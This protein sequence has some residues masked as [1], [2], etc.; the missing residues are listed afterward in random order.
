MAEHEIPVPR[1]HL[2]LYGCGIRCHKIIAR[3]D[4]GNFSNDLS[5]EIDADHY[6]MFSTDSFGYTAEGIL[7]P[8]AKKMV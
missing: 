1:Y 3:E 8:H 2:L 5:D 6:F 7:N 4:F